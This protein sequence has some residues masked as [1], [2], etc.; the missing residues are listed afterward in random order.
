[1]AVIE[2]QNVSKV[3]G[4][5]DA[6]T[7]A[8][9][10]I[11]LTVEKG[12]FVAVMGPSGSGK[13]TLLN[14]IG[15]LDRPSQGIYLLNERKVSRLRSTQRAKA[16]RDHI[17]FIFQSFNLLPKLNVMENVALPLAYRGVGKT[18]RHKRA[19]EMLD[20]VG[21]RL[22]DYYLPRQLSGGQQ[23]PL[24]AY[25]GAGA[26]CPRCDPDRRAFAAPW[27]AGMGSLPEQ[28]GACQPRPIVTAARRAAR[29]GSG[30]RPAHDEPGGPQ[31][32]GRSDGH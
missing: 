26:A 20:K 6:T 10:D 16:R 31:V 27:L 12:E 32:R 4:F 17:G 1:M 24:G 14:I 11:T 2:L 9:D 21:L 25:G 15:I 22:K 7:V 13:S 30:S 5:G 18:R 29:T 19:S 3:F 28:H 8:I 23:V